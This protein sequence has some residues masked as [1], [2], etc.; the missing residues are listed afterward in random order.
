MAE[1]EKKHK[2]KAA[3]DEV[4]EHKQPWQEKYASPEEIED[5]LKDHIHLRRNV[6]TLRTEYRDPSEW[7][8]ERGE[9]KDFAPATDRWQPMSDWKLNTLWRRMMKE[10]PVLFDHMKK[11]INSDSFQDYHP[12]RYYLEHLPPWDRKNDYILEMS[13]SVNVKGG[14]E[15]QL[16]FAEYLRKWLV[17]MVAGW[18]D[19]RE[20][21]HVILIFVGEQGI[22]KTTWFN[23]VLPP[24]LRSYFYTK[25]NASRMT[26]D[27]LLALAQYG[28]VCYE[29]L[30]TMTSKELN[31]LKSAVTMPSVDER[32]PYASF[33][34]HRKHIAS[35][36][37]TGN[38]VQFLSDTTGTRRWLPFEVESIMSPR[39]N[40]FNYEGI[41]AQAYALYQEGF[42]YW[43]SPQEIRQLAQHNSQF[44]TP[45]DELDLVNYYFAKP[46]GANAG[47]FMPTAIAQQIV[48]GL[49]T[50][51]STV[52]LGRA[53]RK[54]GFDSDTVDGSRGFYVV[55]R[56]DEERR[57]RARSLAMEVKNNKTQ[58][59]DDTD[60]F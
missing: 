36:C 5:F 40:P 16:R 38:N 10:K 19:E 7:K 12:F 47:E 17:A 59:T 52:G 46:T 51:V 8:E 55:R 54:L 6:V 30:D 35:F 14:V 20:V 43:F 31:Q 48:S 24:E 23:Y 42:H 44:E 39:E 22:Y 50:R 1:K 3:E 25:T 49:G 9:W 4:K 29:E 15:E 26:K 45:K 41:Y 58:M 13:V 33:A 2:K 56:T 57:T 21:N 60:V 34:D 27:D 53:F 32:A 37:G 28:L 11:V 18:V